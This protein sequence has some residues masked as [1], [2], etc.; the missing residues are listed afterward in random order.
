MRFAILIVALLATACASEP[1]SPIIT[2]A[3]TGDV[4]TIRALAAAGADLNALGP[5]HWTPM[6]HAIHKSQ[7]D[8]V[9]VLITAGADVNRL[10]RSGNSALEMAVANGQ[11][12]IVR[13]L[14]DAGADPMHPGVFVA[15]VSGG[16]FSDIERPW[17]G[18]CHTDV[19]RALL[20]KA[21][22]LKLPDNDDG[23]LSMFFARWNRCTEV[24]QLAQRG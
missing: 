1:P 9:S 19:V 14:L 21:P 7:A 22:D 17:L 8:A 3:R 15:A 10:T 6:M 11:T 20:E 23:Y 13:R 16:A 4:A 18:E 2:A 24:I 5:N 12:G